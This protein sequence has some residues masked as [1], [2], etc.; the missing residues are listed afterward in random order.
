MFI[1]C[2]LK[3]LLLLLLK[4]FKNIAI[5]TNKYKASKIFKSNYYVLQKR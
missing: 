1:K 3:I 4:K 5:Y 2:L